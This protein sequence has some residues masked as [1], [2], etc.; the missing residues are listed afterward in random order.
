MDDPVV[1]VERI[2]G[3]D[4]GHRVGGR[5]RG[6]AARIEVQ[7]PRSKCEWEKAGETGSECPT[8]S[9]AERILD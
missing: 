8:S 5:S 1:R 4:R 9:D 2:D 7:I 6:N 3:V